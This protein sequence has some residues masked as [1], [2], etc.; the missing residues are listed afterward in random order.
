MYIHEC[1]ENLNSLRSITTNRGAG[2]TETQSVVVKIHFNIF[3]FRLVLNLSVANLLSI[4]LLTPLSLVE[5]LVSEVTPVFCTSWSLLTNITSGRQ[6]QRGI[7]ATNIF[8]I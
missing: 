1:N 2:G 5:L 7:L 8:S 4:S 3:L 6:S